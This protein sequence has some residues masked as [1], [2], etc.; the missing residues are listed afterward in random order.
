MPVTFLCANHRQQLLADERLAEN[1]W[2]ESMGKAAEYHETGDFSSAIP[3]LGCALELS[4]HLLDRSWPNA[5]TALSR[6]TASVI[7]L[8]KTYHLSGN[9]NA[10][11]FT[12]ERANERVAASVSDIRCYQLI[13]DSIAVFNWTAVN[14]AIQRCQKGF[15]SNSCYSVSFENYQQRRSAVTL[16]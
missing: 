7:G 5:A 14:L 1:Y 15:V 11:R 3:L 13:C 10:K 12:I 4:G 2:I 6:F 16:H 8:A 9:D